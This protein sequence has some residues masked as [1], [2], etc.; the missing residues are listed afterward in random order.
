MLYYGFGS[1]LAF[2]PIVF[3]IINKIKV[4]N[5]NKFIVSHFDFA[6]KLGFGY[7]NRQT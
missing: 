7:F 5:N 1:M 4:F 3:F 6:E 2:P